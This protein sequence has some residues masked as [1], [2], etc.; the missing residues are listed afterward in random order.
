MQREG[1]EDNKREHKTLAH[2]SRLL[3]L[4]PQSVTYALAN[5]FQV[6]ESNF[7]IICA[8]LPV[9]R[10]PLKQ[11]L[12]KIFGSTRRASHAYYTDDSFE[13]QYVMQSISNKDKSWRDVSV[14]A[15]GKL[16][17]SGRRMSEDE[18]GIIT[19]STEPARLDAPDRGSGA[20]S[21]FSQHAIRKKVKIS[22][23]LK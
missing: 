5:L 11:F 4:T 23:D 17:S 21:P 20:T 10:I 9:L 16:K 22:V 3:K 19:E 18:L 1:D 15:N 7:G 8:C 13:R 6:L 14:S 12:P 2:V